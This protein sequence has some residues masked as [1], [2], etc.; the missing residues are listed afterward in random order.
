MVALENM[1]GEKV[2]LLS[3]DSADINDA[4]GLHTIPAEY[5]Q[6]LN[7]SDL[8]P[9]QLELL[10]A[11]THLQNYQR[12]HNFYCQAKWHVA[13]LHDV[14]FNNAAYGIGLKS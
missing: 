7:P 13:L 4:D 6:S 1:P 11:S 12:I 9:S 8:H 3:T 14:H 10:A 5:L 2:T